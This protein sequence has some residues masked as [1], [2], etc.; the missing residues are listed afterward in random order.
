MQAQRAESAICSV[1]THHQVHRRDADGSHSE[2]PAARGIPPELTKAYHRDWLLIPIEVWPNIP[3][4]MQTK[5]GSTSDSAR[6]PA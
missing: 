3:H 2:Q 4:S 5:S 6:G 1:S